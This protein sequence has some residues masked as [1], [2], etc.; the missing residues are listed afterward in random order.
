MSGNRRRHANVIPLASILM[1]ILVCAFVGAAGLGY[2][3]LKNQL[4]TGA[5]EIRKLERGIEQ[6]STRI[7]GVKGDI[8]R[9]SSMEELR[10]RYQGDKSKLG[11]LVDIRN[12]LVVHMDR[13]LPTT[14]SDSDQ[15]QQAV[16]TTQT[17]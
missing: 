5:D 8:N 17:Q 7:T 9:L 3:S 13:P 2:V 14:I 12:E 11:G 6:V 4:H 15:L 10:K 16:H 1:W